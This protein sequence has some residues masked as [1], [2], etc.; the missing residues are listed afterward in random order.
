MAKLAVDTHFKEKN[1]GIGSLM[2]ELAVSLALCCNE[3]QSSRFLTVDA[4]IEHDPGL[5]DFYK[6]NHFVLNEKM[7]ARKMPKTISMRR[8]LYGEYL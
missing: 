8:D 7:N 1:K 5:I 4:D 2:V 3:Y 6:K